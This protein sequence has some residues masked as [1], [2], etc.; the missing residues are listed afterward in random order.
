MAAEC[1]VW[2]PRTGIRG[3]AMT[4][5]L[6]VATQ[7][8]C[9]ESCDATLDGCNAVS[10]RASKEQCFT[11]SVTENQVS[12]THE[13]FVSKRRCDPGELRPSAP[14]CESLEAEISSSL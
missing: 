13:D 3:E 1:D 5:Q 14:C 2:L 10:Y 11:M 12:E 6:G 7:E 8:Q 9:W 4:E